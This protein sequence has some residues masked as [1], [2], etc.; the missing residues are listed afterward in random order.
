[1]RT[2]ITRADFVMLQHLH[3]TWHRALREKVD[4][5]LTI[6]KEEKR[7]E[8]VRSYD[9][10]GGRYHWWL[11]RWRQLLWDDRGFL[12]PLTGEEL[13]RVRTTLERFHGMRNRL[14]PELRDIGQYRTEMDLRTI[15][16][17]R[18]AEG[19]LRAEK[20][21]LRSAADSQSDTLFHDGPWRI[22]LL[23]G[24]DA[25]RFWGL[26]TKWCTTSDAATY[27]NYARVAPLVVFLSPTGKYQMHLGGDFRNETNGHVGAGWSEGAPAGYHSVLARLT[28]TSNP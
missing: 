7:F 17:T 11:S 13:L 24:Y 1:M 4:P 10:T 16:P 23:R 9:P 12:T 19:R 21:A 2:R 18:I 26:G 6:E 8:L 27:E 3:A 22:V 28:G 20:A 25:A 5:Q 15:V 14:S